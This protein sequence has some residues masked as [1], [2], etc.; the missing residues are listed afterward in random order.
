MINVLLLMMK[1][2]GI[3]NFYLDL[4]S[5]ETPCRDDLLEAPLPSWLELQSSSSAMFFVSFLSAS[6]SLCWFLRF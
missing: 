1:A 4:S 5:Q 3:L 6:A 2:N